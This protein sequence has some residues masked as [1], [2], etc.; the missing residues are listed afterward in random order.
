MRLQSRLHSRFAVQ[1]VDI[2]LEQAMSI[3]YQFPPKH[4]APESEVAVTA[5]RYIRYICIPP[6]CNVSQS[7][8]S[9]YNQLWL[10]LNDII[11]GT[12]FSAFI[13]E[14]NELIADF[15]AVQSK[16]SFR[17]CKAHYAH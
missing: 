16:V 3:A 6:Y 2:R 4:T 17:N 14:H 5:A 13:Y 8:C 7:S 11:I 9:F 15:L 10:I 12:A 1:Q